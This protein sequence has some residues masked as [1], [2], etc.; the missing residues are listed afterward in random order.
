MISYSKMVIFQRS[1]KIVNILKSFVKYTLT[2]L[3]MMLIKYYTIILVSYNLSA[4]GTKTMLI[5]NK[6][7]NKSCISNMIVRRNKISLVYLV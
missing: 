4:L 2:T 3:A 5:A 7:A 6:R 1:I